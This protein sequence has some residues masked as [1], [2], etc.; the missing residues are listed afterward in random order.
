MSPSN[1]KFENFARAFAEYVKD[2][3]WIMTWVT[4]G[5]VSALTAYVMLRC[6]WVV[7]KSIFRALNI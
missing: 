2:I 6:T 3:I 4:I 5:L 7:A 1:H